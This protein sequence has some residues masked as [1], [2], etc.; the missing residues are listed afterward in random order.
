MVAPRGEEAV[1]QRRVR[2]EARIGMS[3]L[4]ELILLVRS[5]LREQIKNAS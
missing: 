5:G 1:E 2:K 4:A 3:R